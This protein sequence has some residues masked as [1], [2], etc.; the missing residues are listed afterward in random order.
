MPPPASSL[1]EVSTRPA[2]VRHMPRVVVG[3]TTAPGEPSPTVARESPTHS[4]LASVHAL[5]VRYTVVAIGWALL[6]IY[7]AEVFSA[8]R[9]H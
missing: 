8:F 1:S 2:R 5:V 6:G 7:C 3:A 9:S 4:H